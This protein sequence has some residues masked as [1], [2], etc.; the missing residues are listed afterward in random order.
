MPTVPSHIPVQPLETEGDWSRYI[1]FTKNGFDGNAL[2]TS[3]GN[4]FLRAK[5]IEVAATLVLWKPYPSLPLVLRQPQ[6]ILN[7]SVTDH[8]GERMRFPNLPHYSVVIHQ[9]T[10]PHP[11]V[12]TSQCR[13]HPQRILLDQFRNV[14]V[15]LNVTASQL[16]TLP[17]ADPSPS[18]TDFDGI[19]ELW[20]RVIGEA[21]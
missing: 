16:R 19:V 13:N 7:F 4:R 8:T 18:V 21:D 17:S 15:Q 3:Y 11:T 14:F 1:L 6:G 20:V 12:V 2:K 9:R 10:F 5:E